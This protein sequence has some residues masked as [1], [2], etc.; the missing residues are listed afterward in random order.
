MDMEGVLRRRYE[1][2]C[3]GLFLVG[4]ILLAPLNAWSKRIELSKVLADELNLLLSAVDD[5]HEAF[6]D[7]DRS[8][9]HDSLKGVLS[10]LKRARVK[11]GKMKTLQAP[12]V[13]RYLDAISRHLEMVLRSNGE[14]QSDELRKAFHQL[15]GLLRTYQLRKDFHI[16][17]CDH[18]K[19]TWVQKGWKARHPLKP[20]V[21]CGLAVM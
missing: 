20:K 10:A 5:M 7:Q 1:Q 8:A 15:A 9:V 18:D 21:R 4:M 6:V 3:W 13:L 16:F 17:F 2:G 14:E 12:H 11:T 19:M